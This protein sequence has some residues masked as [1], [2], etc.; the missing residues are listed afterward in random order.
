MSLYFFP[1]L[2]DFSTMTMYR[3]LLTAASFAALAYAALPFSQRLSLILPDFNNHNKTSSPLRIGIIGASDIAKFAVLWPASRHPNAVVHAVA[4][5]DVGRAKAYAK[6]HHIPVVHETYQKLMQDPNIDAVYIGVITELHFSLAKLALENHKHVL[7]EKPA[8]FTSDEA[9][10]LSALSTSVRKTLFEAFHWRYHPA[11]IRVKELL[12][13]EKIVGSINQLSLKASLFDPK[14]I[15]PSKEHVKLFDRWCYLVDELH[16]YLGS[17][18][19]I[20]VQNVSMTPTSMQANLTAHH[21]DEQVIEISMDAYRDKLEL[22]SWFLS[23]NGSKGRLHYENT[24]FPFLYHRI[25]K[26]N[27]EVEKKYSFREDDVGKTTF[28]YQLEEFIR[29]VQQRDSD[30]ALLLESMM[31]NADLAKRIVKHIGREPK[32]SWSYLDG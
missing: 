25:E 1:R 9:K 2:Q 22:P 4:A 5:R 18:Y 10:Q 30:D 29:I 3:S 8:V 20:R 14:H 26:P 24:L 28:A 7:L 15:P 23:V 6:R 21:I 32:Q 31:R 13:N 12:T 27:G 19:D 11:A 17:K 16:F